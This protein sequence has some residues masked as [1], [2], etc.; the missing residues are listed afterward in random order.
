[1]EKFSIWLTY[2]LGLTGDLRGLFT[3]L[4]NNDAVECGSNNAF[5]KIDLQIKNPFPDM[6]DI[7]RALRALLLQYMT[8]NTGDRIYVVFKS[9]VDNN[10]SGGM[11]IYGNRMASPWIGYRNILNNESFTPVDK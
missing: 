4:D 1:M 5:F 3:F 6:G 8:I 7:Q 9:D 10:K 2:D 11:F